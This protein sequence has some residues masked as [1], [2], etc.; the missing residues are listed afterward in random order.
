MI[1]ILKQ[2]RGKM[3]NGLQIRNSLNEKDI[4]AIVNLAEVCNRYEQ[5]D[6]ITSLNLF[7]LHN[8]DG[9]TVNDFLYF[10]NSQLTG[11]LGM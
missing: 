9:K 2:G 4:Q 3:L 11:F 6:M 5:L 1:I 7:K 10:H 8:R